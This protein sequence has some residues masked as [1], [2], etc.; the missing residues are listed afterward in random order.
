MKKRGLIIDSY[1]T[2]AR[3]FTMTKLHLQTPE[4]VEKFVEVDGMHGSLDY[5]EAA[6]GEPVYRP[7]SLSAVFEL[8]SGDHASRE[9]EF[10]DL[11]RAVHGKKC[12]IIHPDHPGKY[13]IGRVQLSVDFNNLAFGQ[14]SLS[15][16]CEP[17]FFEF[18]DAY[19]ELPILDRSHN[20]AVYDNIEA[21]AELSTCTGSRIG[22]TEIV[23]VTLVTAPAAVHT[24]AVFRISLKPNTTYYLSGSLSGNGYWR[25]SANAQMPE[26]FEPIAATGSDGY[27]YIFV[28]RLQSF[29]YVNLQHLVCLE[30]DAAAILGNG[31]ATSKVSFDV[32]AGLRIIMMLN[33]RSIVMFGH[34]SKVL[35]VPAGDAPAAAF[36]TDTTEEVDVAVLRWRR[37][38]LE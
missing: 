3:G 25:V 2:A 23:T 34:S 31:S 27:L 20:C 21:L 13:L 18:T 38:W 4:I 15:A 29:G 35:S 10:T 28:T 17:W 37:G 16:T 19:L 22:E 32:P 33:G 5:C 7:R 12:R 1:D 14:V 24:Y 36:R 9:K 11:L 26:T 8:S 30:A 6:T